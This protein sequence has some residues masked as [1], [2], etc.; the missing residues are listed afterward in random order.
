MRSGVVKRLAVCVPVLEH[1]G[2]SPACVQLKSATIDVKLT[3]LGK[4]RQHTGI[5]PTAS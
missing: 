2:T 5:N 1:C 4:L 3:G